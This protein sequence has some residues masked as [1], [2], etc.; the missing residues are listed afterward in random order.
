MLLVSTIRR[1]W[2]SFPLAGVAAP[3]VPCAPA[4]GTHRWQRFV[5]PDELAIAVGRVGP[6]PAHLRG[7]RYPPPVYRASR[8]RD[9]P[10]NYIKTFARPVD[11]NAP[12]ANLNDRR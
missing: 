8:I 5:R 4:R 3:Y 12:T 10:I 7:M 11:E 2:K 9:T 6:F 1:R